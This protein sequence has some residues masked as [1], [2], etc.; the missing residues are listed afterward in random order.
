[1]FRAL[2]VLSFFCYVQSKLVNLSCNHVRTFVEGH[3]VRRRWLAER[4]IFDQPAAAEMNAVVWDEELAEKAAKWADKN[5]HEHNPDRTLASRRFETGE[6]IY[7]YGTTDA[8]FLFNVDQAMKSWFDEHQY[9]KYGPLLSKDFDGSA[10]QEIGH[11]TQQMAWSDTTYIGCA[12]S[13]VIDGRWNRYYVVCN[14]GPGGNYIGQAPY[15]SNGSASYQLQCNVK[16]CRHPYGDHCW[17]L[18]YV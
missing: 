16:Q 9:Y 14:Y 13:K 4:R 2:L 11:Y 15:K 18:E 12:V 5:I 7:W 17:G 10:T 3:N 6:N 1:M 8:N